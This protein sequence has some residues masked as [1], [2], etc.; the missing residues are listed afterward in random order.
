VLDGLGDSDAVRVLTDA[1]DRQQHH[2]FEIPQRLARHLFN[3]TYDI[4][5]E[6]S[7]C[8]S[9]QPKPNVLAGRS[10]DSGAAREIFKQLRHRTQGQATRWRAVRMSFEKYVLAN[11]GPS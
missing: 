5:P 9:P 3:Y 1:E 8:V 10:S 4:T 11:E 2:Q 7:W 6:T